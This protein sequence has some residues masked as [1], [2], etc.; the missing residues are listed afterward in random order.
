MFQFA[1]ERD[2]FQI[3][4]KPWLRLDG[5]DE[6]DDNPEITEYI[7]KAEA[8][9]VYKK[10]GHSISAVMTNNLSFNGNRGSIQLNYLYPV[11]NNLRLHLQLFSGYGESLIDY[12]YYQTTAGIGLSFVDW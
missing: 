1:M 4:L 8:T 11:E 12:N 5:G 10:N 3:Y 6:A 7:G 2:N 9:M